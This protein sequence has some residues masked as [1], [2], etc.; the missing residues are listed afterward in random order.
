MTTY[1]L[2]EIAVEAALPQAQTLTEQDMTGPFVGPLSVMSQGGRIFL[3]FKKPNAQRVTFFEFLPTTAPW[4]LHE[5]GLQPGIYFKDGDGGI[6]FGPDGRGY[7][8]TTS[9]PDPATGNAA[10]VVVSDDFPLVV[11]PPGGGGT[12]QPG[13]PGP[14]GHPGSA[15]QAGPAGARGSSGAS[16]PQGVPG[17]PGHGWPGADWDWQQAI[18]AQYGQLADK[19]SGAYGLVVAIIEAALKAHGI[20]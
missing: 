6:G 20:K 12:G 8:F 5:F 15:G 4:S 10:R 1:E 17:P 2:A 18:N 3:A 14:P 16:G 11:A 7:F 13:Q 9:S 19:Q